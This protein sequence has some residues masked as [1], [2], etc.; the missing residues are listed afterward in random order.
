MYDFSDLNSDDI[1]YNKDVNKLKDNKYSILYCKDANN[2]SF[3]SINNN[4]LD[5]NKS[6][7]DSFDLIKNIEDH[8][9]SDFNRM[10]KYLNNKDNINNNLC[11]G[12]FC[13][14]IIPL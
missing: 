12:Y 2:N 14:F 3:D 1:E 4:F 11:S 10:M 6:F 9:V 7:Y 5:K 8:E 13:S